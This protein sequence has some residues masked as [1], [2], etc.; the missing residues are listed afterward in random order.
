[1]IRILQTQDVLSSHIWIFNPKTL[2]RLI[3][4]KRDLDEKRSEVHHTNNLQL[5]KEVYLSISPNR[6]TIYHEKL[7]KER[8]SLLQPILLPV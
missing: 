4:P 6:K 2:A 3:Q 7:G 1:M 8:S 5:E